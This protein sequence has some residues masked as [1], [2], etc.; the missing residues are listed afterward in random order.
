MRQ[1]MLD[2]M[3]TSVRMLALAKPSEFLFAHRSG[4][5][6][7][8]GQTSLPFTLNCI[9]SGPIALSFRG[10]FLLVIALRFPCREWLRNC[11]HA[12]SSLFHQSLGR[13]LQRCAQERERAPAQA[14]VP[15]VLVSWERSG[16][17]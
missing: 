8:G 6:I 17:P 2:N 5:S 13:R 9:A 15:V 11:Q 3:F 14:L 4:Q 16:R 1:S 10:E 7:F 12:F